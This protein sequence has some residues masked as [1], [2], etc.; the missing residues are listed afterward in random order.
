M[1]DQQLVK[2]CLKGKRDAQYLLYDMHAEYMLG[3]CYRYTKSMSDA[4]DV[5]QD[6][7]IKVFKNLHQYKFDGDLAAWIRR[8]MVNTAIN[9][10]KQQSRSRLDLNFTETSLHPV[11]SDDPEINLTVKE[12]AELIRQLPTGYQTIFNL[13]A[14][15][16]YTHVEIGKLLGIHEGTSRS[17][18]ARARGLLVLWL[19]KNDVGDK[20][21]VY[22][23]NG[24]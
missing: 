22:A 1:N 14:I 9:Y 18:Y 5:L 20:T 19:G 7:F 4:E 6:G 23:Q 15:E 17:Q 24:I 8:I 13:H 3:V 12:L 10:L 11:S 2:N 21:T 16:G